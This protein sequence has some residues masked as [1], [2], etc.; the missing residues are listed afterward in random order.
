MKR[1]VGVFL[2]VASVATAGAKAADCTRSSVGFVPLNDLGA[3]TY[4]GMT[5]GL[6][7][8]G[9]NVRPGGH[10]DLGTTLAQMAVPRNAA[11]LPDPVGGKL[12]FLSI[13]MSNTRNE[14]NALA[15][16]IAADPVRDSR[17]VFVNGAQGGMD[18]EKTKT[19][20]SPYWSYVDQQVAAAGATALQVQAVWLKQA[21]AGINKAFPAD[22]LQLQADLRA[23]VQILRQKFP[24]LN[25]VYLSSRIYAGYATTSLNPEPYAY[26]SGFAVKWLIESQ[27]DGTYSRDDPLNGIAT[28]WLSW[29]AYLWA[30]GSVPRSDG[31]AYACGDFNSDG[32]HPN[33]VGS[34]KVAD[35]L[36]SWLHSDPTTK[37]WY[38]V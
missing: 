6:Y 10:T 28:P 38:E 7:P 34:A 15:S 9:S 17:V 33:T 30:D 22:A 1:I 3:G 37:I 26:Q 8:G 13:G 27:I 29:A 18:A 11:G 23:I 32:T 5:G 25:L 16:R 35:Q 12:V 21:I 20:T 36:M 2:V 19:I 14:S 24:N 31:L 4:Q